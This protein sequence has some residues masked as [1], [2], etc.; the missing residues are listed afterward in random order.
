HAGH[1][2][3]RWTARKG[4]GAARTDAESEDWDG[5]L[6]SGPC[7]EG[8]QSRQGGV[9]AGQDGNHS[10]ADRKSQFWSAAACG[11]RAG[12]VERGVE[13]QA[14]DSE[15]QVLQEGDAE[16]DDGPGDFD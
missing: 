6:R 8:N 2:E 12:A 1:D 5:D 15:G 7:G 3:V 13:G 9:P 16:F 14:G 10:L 4:A 11:K